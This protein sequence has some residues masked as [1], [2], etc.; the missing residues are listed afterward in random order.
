MLSLSSLISHTGTTPLPSGK[1]IGM[2]ADFMRALA[3]K[4]E[5]ASLDFKLLPFEFHLLSPHDMAVS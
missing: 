4:Y 3:R 2:D 5:W 1:L